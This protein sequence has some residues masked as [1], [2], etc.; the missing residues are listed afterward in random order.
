MSKVHTTWTEATTNVN[1]AMIMLLSCLDSGK[2]AWIEL[3]KNGD[4]AYPIKMKNPELDNPFNWE[5]S[6][7]TPR[8]EKEMMNY[9]YFN[10]T[11]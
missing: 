10:D 1:K 3:R 2:N 8:N 7:S 5:M 11:E 4:Q 6:Y 9:K